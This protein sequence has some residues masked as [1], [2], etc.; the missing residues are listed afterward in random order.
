M[1][2]ALCGTLSTN[3]LICLLN[4]R[5]C[6][7]GHDDEQGGHKPEQVHK[8]SKADSAMQQCNRRFLGNPVSFCSLTLGLGIPFMPYAYP[9]RY[10]TLPRVLC[11]NVIK[12]KK[13]KKEN[14]SGS[15]DSQQPPCN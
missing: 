12:K 1:Y 9:Y 3:Q 14:A 7:L 13:K 5:P 8:N 15:S 4:A 2:T 11:L 10:V 6:S